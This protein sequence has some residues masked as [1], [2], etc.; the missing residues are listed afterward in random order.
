[1][2]G[3]KLILDTLEISHPHNLSSLNLDLL[4][5]LRRVKKVLISQFIIKNFEIYQLM[6]LPESHLK[7]TNGELKNVRVI[8]HGDI[9]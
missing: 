6:L 5:K 4:L 3:H 7:L 1:M 2:E 9:Q 8:T